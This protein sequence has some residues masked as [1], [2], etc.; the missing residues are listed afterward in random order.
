MNNNA[1]H[2]DVAYTSY[3]NW[4]HLIEPLVDRS[5]AV[6]AEIL[7]IKQKFGSLRFYVRSN[8]ELLHQ[9]VCAAEDAS[10]D[11]PPRDV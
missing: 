3:P 11:I 2:A 5:N 7:Q 1:I 6:G 9:M 4:R 8:D 10:E